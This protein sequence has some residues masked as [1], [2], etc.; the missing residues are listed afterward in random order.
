V[1]STCAA[2]PYGRGSQWLPLVRIGDLVVSQAGFGLTYASEQVPDGTPL[3]P[4]RVPSSN[5]LNPSAPLV[6]PGMKELPGGFVLSA[7]N[8]SASRAHTV[9]SFAVRIAGFSPYG[10]HLNAWNFCADGSYDAH[11]GKAS[12]GGC[13][14]G[15]AVNEALHAT[16]A[17][18]ASVG[19]TVK[20]TQTGTF[21]TGPHTGGTFPP[22][23][24]A[25]APGK[26]VSVNI[27]LTV[28]TAPGAHTFAFGGAIDGAA[29]VFFSTSAPSLVAPVT[30]E[31][32]GASCTT[33]SMKQQIPPAATSTRYICP[34]A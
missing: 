3:Q 2:I 7:C 27:G 12:V 30:R 21:F 25:L 32:D 11:T 1:P 34:K 4:L 24:L 10:G 33:P 5:S 6:N 22:L 17:A 9:Q 29:P 20:A 26:S 15:L 8:V 19:T 28:P 18:D 13:G 23:P 14:G 31:W 16:F